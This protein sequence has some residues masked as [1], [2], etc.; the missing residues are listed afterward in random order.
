M[1]KATKH[2]LRTSL[3]ARFN[4]LANGQLLNISFQSFLSTCD[5]RPFLE[6]SVQSDLCEAPGYG[7]TL[8]VHLG[9]PHHLLPSLKQHQGRQLL[10]QRRRRHFVPTDTNPHAHVCSHAHP[11]RTQEAGERLN[12]LLFGD[13]SVTSDVHLAKLETSTVIPET[14]K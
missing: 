5:V 6:C 9:A 7:S 3:P 10:G 2:K 1:H 8:L 12:V 14:H 4:T 11:S 13:L